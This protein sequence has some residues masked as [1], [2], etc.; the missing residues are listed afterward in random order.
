MLPFYNASTKTRISIAVCHSA[1]RSSLA[2]SSAQPGRYAPAA[3]RNF[4]SALLRR[5]FPHEIFLG[6]AGPP[7][8]ALAPD[9]SGDSVIRTTPQSNPAVKEPAARAH[10]DRNPGTAHH[11]IPPD[12]PS[13]HPRLL[14]L[15][16][17]SGVFR[18]HA[19]AGAGI[20]ASSDNQR[21][22]TLANPS[23]ESGGSNPA[24]KKA[25][26]AQLSCCKP[27]TSP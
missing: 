22:F 19:T 10:M 25:K 1:T 27:R 11:Q 24:R 7:S 6:S 16:E 14:R 2:G 18:G 15:Q 4:R 13:G 20:S 3:P 12:P 23:C 9:P 21:T 5:L 26:Q 8:C 17:T